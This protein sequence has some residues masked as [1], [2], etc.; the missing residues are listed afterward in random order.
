MI[1]TKHATSHAFTI[2][3][4]MTSARPVATSKYPNASPHV[5]TTAA[6]R[7]NSFHA[8]T[9]APDANA[10][11]SLVSTVALSSDATVLTDARTALCQQ[12]HPA[13]AAIVSCVAGKLAAPASTRSPSSTATSDPQSGTPRTNDLVPSIG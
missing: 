1:G 12:P 10:R 11:S 8:S 9:V 7:A 6:R 5:R 2:A 3:S 13:A 4:T